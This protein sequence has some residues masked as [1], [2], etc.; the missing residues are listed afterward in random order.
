MAEKNS[1]SDEARR[2][3]NSI[4]W[5]AGEGAWRT[6]PL[7]SGNPDNFERSGATTD[8][9]GKNCVE[10]LVGVCVILCFTKGGGVGGEKTI[11]FL[12]DCAEGGQGL[13][14]PKK[15]ITRRE[16]QLEHNFFGQNAEKLVAIQMK[17][18][19]V[20]LEEGATCGN[21]VEGRRGWPPK[22]KKST[23]A[24]PRMRGR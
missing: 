2:V 12:W 5:G 22:P 9:L 6:G 15:W 4:R 14:P 7:L 24:K 3:N 23:K 16:K 11:F 21:R 13:D 8:F 1:G 10:S 20:R 19:L 17:V 18:P